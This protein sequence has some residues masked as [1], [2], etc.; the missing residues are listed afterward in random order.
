MRRL[1][2]PAALAGQADTFALAAAAAA[3]WFKKPGADAV[4]SA[5]TA[6][7][8]AAGW[9]DEAVSALKPA[10][11]AKKGDAADLS[12]ALREAVEHAAAAVVEAARQELPADKELAAGAAALAAGAKSL[13]AALAASGGARADALVDAKRW[14]GECERRRRAVR[15][16]AHEDP[17]FV[18]ALTREKAA[19]RLSRAAEALQRAVDVLGADLS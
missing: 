13:A 9:R 6:R 8:R 4:A 11:G 5:R 15:A 14:A 19:D 1:D 12:F 18:A 7:L 16:D 3:R 10:R 17:A 2:A